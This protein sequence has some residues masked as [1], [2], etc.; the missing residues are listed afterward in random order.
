L[1]TN[2]KH[3]NGNNSNKE[4]NKVPKRR[5]KKETS[6]R[7]NEFTALTG[8]RLFSTIKGTKLGTI[9]PSGH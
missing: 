7:V 4:N 5:P 9:F 8:R 1:K 2:N 3:N 6:P